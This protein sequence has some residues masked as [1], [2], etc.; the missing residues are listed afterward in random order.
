[1]LLPAR[2]EARLLS[3][4]R[5]MTSLAPVR[6][7]LTGPKSGALSVELG[8]HVDQFIPDNE[9]VPQLIP[10]WN[11]FDSLADAAPPGAL[12]SAAAECA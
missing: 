3:G 10:F 12:A 5:Q 6:L 4:G 1:M 11:K 9:M 8:A 7:R 2:M